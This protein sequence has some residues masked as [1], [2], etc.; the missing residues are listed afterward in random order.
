MTK[1]IS[2]MKLKASDSLILKGRN[3]KEGKEDT[4]NSSGNESDKIAMHQEIS[5]NLMEFNHAPTRRSVGGGGGLKKG[6]D[7]KSQSK[8][9]VEDAET[10][11]EIPANGN[12]QIPRSSNSGVPAKSPKNSRSNLLKAKR[13]YPSLPLLSRPEAEGQ[14]APG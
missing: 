14:D 13:S 7:G 5:G 10:S 9:W 4:G 2:S 6:K 11:Q 1:V 12:F 3:N 8:D